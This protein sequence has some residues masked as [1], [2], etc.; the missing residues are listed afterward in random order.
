MDCTLLFLAIN[1]ELLT[2]PSGYNYIP[3]IYHLG[4]VI[5]LVVTDRITIG[6]F[7]LEAVRMIWS[8]SEKTRY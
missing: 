7:T 3:F 4:Y 6:I 5:L 2:M 1:T 8:V